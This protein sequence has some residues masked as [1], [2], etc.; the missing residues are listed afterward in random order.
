MTDQQDLRARLTEIAYRDSA[1][2]VMVCTEDLKALLDAAQLGRVGDE[3]IDC[4]IAVAPATIFSVGVK[5]S[6]VVS[7]VRA[8][9]EA[10]GTFAFTAKVRDRVAE[11]QLP[12]GVPDGWKI[13]RVF[14]R[15]DCVVITTP[16]GLEWIA[17]EGDRLHTLATALTAAPQPDIQKSGKGEK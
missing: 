5:L 7:A 10:E 13:E 16:T 1:V 8:R 3:T 2:S 12:A 14:G 6:T 4:E 9:K 11:P 15:H 17:A